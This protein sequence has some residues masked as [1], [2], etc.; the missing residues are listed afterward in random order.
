MTE[1]DRDINVYWIV[2]KICTLRYTPFTWSFFS[3]S[4]LSALLL[5]L[6]LGILLLHRG[7]D[8][9]VLNGVYGLL[10]VTFGN[11]P[12]FRKLFSA[13]FLVLWKNFLVL[14]YHFSLLLIY[15]KNY[16][17]IIMDKTSLTASF[18]YEVLV[19]RGGLISVVVPA[20]VMFLFLGIL[21]LIVPRNMC[22]N[23]SCIN[24]PRI[25]APLHFLIIGLVWSMAFIT[26]LLM[27]ALLINLERKRRETKRRLS[28]SVITKID[29]AK[30]LVNIVIYAVYSIT[31]TFPPSHQPLSAYLEFVNCLTG[32]IFF[33]NFGLSKFVRN[34]YSG[35]L[36]KLTKGK[37]KKISSDIEFGFALSEDPVNIPVENVH[38]SEKAENCGE[39]IDSQKH[40]A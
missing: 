38:D 34:V 12:I 7:D 13:F 11:L 30:C 28:R 5:V 15:T 4:L 10:L 20:C 31:Q 32:V 16:P 14:A 23:I 24:I 17:K 25:D 9:V 8:L 6:V 27:I 3:L 39:P 33:L 22:L 18:T 37:K 26:S 2:F 40:N 36:R 19:G 1:N 21:S 35:W 29:V